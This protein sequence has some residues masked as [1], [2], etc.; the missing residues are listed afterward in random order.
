LDSDESAA[1]GPKELIMAAMTVMRAGIPALPVLYG[2][3]NA[4]DGIQ[5][6]TIH[7]PESIAQH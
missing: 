1:V 2:F 5:K 7:I 6:G 4:V 3:P